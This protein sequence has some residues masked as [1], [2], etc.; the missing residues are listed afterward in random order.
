MINNIII[1]MFICVALWLY[2]KNRHFELLF[3]IAVAYVLLPVVKIGDNRGLNSAYVVTLVECVVFLLELLKKRIVVNKLSGSY[4]IMML[5][6][7][8]VAGIGWLVN[9]NPSL[10]QLIHF[11]GM[12]QYII[13]AFMYSVFIKTFS[14]NKRSLMRTIC[15]AIVILNYIMALIQL[16]VWDMGEPLT[17]Q[18]YVY[19]GKEKPLKE[20]CEAG[21]GFVRAFG[22]FYSPSVLGIISLLMSTFFLHDILK[23]KRIGKENVIFYMASIGL[24]LLAFSK[25]AIIGVFL[26]W[27]L[28]FV[29]ELLQKEFK[30]L[31]KLLGK[32][33]GMIIAT[34]LVIGSFQCMI[35]F[36]GYVNWYYLKAINISVAMESRYQNIVDHNEEETKVN[37]KKD[38]TTDYEEVEEATGN[39]KD[40]FSVFLEHPFI[41]VGP[42]AIK[43][44]FLGDSEYITILHN[45][46]ICMFLVYAIFY[47]TLIVYLFLKK[48]SRE[49]FVLLAI[50]MGGISMLVFSYSCVI[51]FLAF[52]IYNDENK[53]KNLG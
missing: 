27:G 10:G 41:G 15:K 25:L 22:T 20:T 37:Q 36:S 32:T 9:G 24:G 11:F 49:L 34:F 1:F 52:C 43:G 5:L 35:G 50:G 46:G 44:E 38:D 48:Y 3:L 8:F 47:G 31:W 17:R 29:F 45:G 23:E 6:G 53:V 42:N 2:K 26:V 12:G 7:L 30:N 40:T 14:L 16:L 33:L 51:P 13:G 18:L 19:A 28:T 39:L 4:L 21:V